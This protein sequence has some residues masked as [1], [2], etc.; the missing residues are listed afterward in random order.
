M[1]KPF[2]ASELFSAIEIRL[3]R[4]Q[5]IKEGLKARLEEFKYQMEKTFFHEFNTPLNGI[6]GGAELLKMYGDEFDRREKEE[7]IDAILKSGRRMKKLLDNN[8]LYNRLKDAGN[9]PE[10]LK[11]T[12]SGGP[13]QA[14]Q[15]IPMALA[16]VSNRYNRPQDLK[17]HIEPAM[18]SISENNLHYLVDE[19]LDNALKFSDEGKSVQISGSIQEGFYVLSIQ[20]R[21][22]GMSAEDLAHVEAYTQFNRDIHEQQGL[23][24][25][26]VNVFMLL[27][28]NR[29]NFEIDTAPKQG[30]AIRMSLPLFLA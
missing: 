23:G 7:L 25:G 26:L 11:N 12:V 24:L 10:L 1:T 2:S 15:V 22:R 13:C 5:E 17:S 9:N 4:N 20:D 27:N 19:L 29:I 18:L 8:V 6:L 30:F 21:G 28:A 14:E 3:N 16:Q